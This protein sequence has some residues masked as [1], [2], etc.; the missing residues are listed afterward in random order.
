MKRV[1]D[2]L[3]VGLLWENAKEVL[4]ESYDNAKKIRISIENKMAHDPVFRGKYGAN[5]KV[6][7]DK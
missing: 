7:I 5:I 3:E 1:G 6:Y 4:S 2:S